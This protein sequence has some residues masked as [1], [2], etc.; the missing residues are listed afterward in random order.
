MH[1]LYLGLA[2]LLELIGTS[3]IKMS[4]GFTKLP[5]TAIFVVAYIVSFYFLSLALRVIP[6]G[7]AYAV[8]SGVGIVCTTLI[9]TFIF[10]QHISLPTV[11]GIALILVGVVVMRL[12]DHSSMHS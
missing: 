7:V 11:I 10:K 4:D 3:F 1:Y 5:A 6:L 2:I 9:S 12:A 8:W